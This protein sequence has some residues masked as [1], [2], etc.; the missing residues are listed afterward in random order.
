MR[1]GC[2]WRKGMGWEE[3]IYKEGGDFGGAG[4]SKC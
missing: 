1:L 2:W 4:D 3:E